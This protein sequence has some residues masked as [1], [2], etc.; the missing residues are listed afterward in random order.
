MHYLLM[1]YLLLVSLIFSPQYIFLLVLVILIEI[2]VAVLAFV[3]KNEVRYGSTYQ[4]L[5]IDK[6][7]SAT[8]PL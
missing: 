1:Q 3:F 6:K 8:R 5:H 2:A 4:G 7:W